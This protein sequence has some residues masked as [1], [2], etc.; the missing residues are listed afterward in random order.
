MF[1]KNRIK[2]LLIRRRIR[3]EGGEQISSTI[4]NIADE[5]YN[6]KVG[7]YSYGCFDPEFNTGGKVLIGRYVSCG[8]AVKYFGANHPIEYGSMSPYFYRKEWGF[9]VKDVSRNT[10]EIGNDCW[11]G[12]NVTIVSSCKKIG[13]GAVIGA[14]AVVTHDVPAYGIVMGVPARIVRYRFDEKTIEMLEKSRWWELDPEK[15]MK[16]Y[17][18]I[19]THEI[20]ARKIYENITSKKDYVTSDL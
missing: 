20:W 12:N 3:K 8:P 5:N 18:F 6:V 9:S 16:Y 19:G 15:L 13:N 1:L 14:G 2:D 4:R 7:K 10:L 11:I 17:E